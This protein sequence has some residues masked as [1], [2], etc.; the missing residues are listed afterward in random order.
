MGVMFS[1]KHP[2]ILTQGLVRLAMQSHR[3]FGTMTVAF[4]L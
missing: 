1:N 2:S 3:Q 4:S